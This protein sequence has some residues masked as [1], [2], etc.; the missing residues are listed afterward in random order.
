[1]KERL[2]ISEMAKLRNVTTE[3]LRHY[4]RIDL[5]KPHAVDVE[6]GYRYYSILQSEVLGTIKELRQIG[7]STT[8]IKEYFDQR[9]MKKSLQFLRLKYDKIQARIEELAELEENIGDKIRHLEDMLARDHAS[10]IFIRQ[11]GMRRLITQ[12]RSINNHLELYYG[13]LELENMLTERAPILATNRLGVL[14]PQEELRSRKTKTPSVVFVIAK[15]MTQVEPQH[16]LVV[17]S[18]KY[19]CIT[20]N[21]KL[22]DREQ[23]LAELYRFIE[24]SGHEIA[25]DALQIIQIDITITD[26]PDEVIFELQIPIL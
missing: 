8:E 17:P 14:I 20:Y 6:T 21:G 9:N 15:D 22:W 13:I 10:G 16:L 25:G 12:G 1:M 11:I 23:Y 3:T 5:F 24:V 2:S 4:D 19:A 26:N 7:I 18:G